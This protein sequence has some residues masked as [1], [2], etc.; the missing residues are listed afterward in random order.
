M[1]RT[2][3]TLIVGGAANREIEMPDGPDVLAK[4]ASGFDFD[5]LGTELQTRDMI[6]LANIFEQSAGGLETTQEQ[7]LEGGR[8]IRV[9]SSV[10]ASINAILEQNG[11]D[12]HMIAAGKIAIAF[13]TLQSESRATLN[14]E[15]IV[16]GDLPLRGSENWLYQLGQMIVKGVPRAKADDCF[17]KLSIICFNYDRSIEHYLPWVLHMGFGMSLEEARA[18]IAARLRIVHPF[19]VAGRLPWQNGDTA[20]I[21]WGYEESNDYSALIKE[22]CT[23]SERWLDRDFTKAL[24]GEVAESERVVFLG[25]G[26]DPMDTALLF[27]HP[28][29]HNRDVLVGLTGTNAI[30]R[31]AIFRLLKENT[32]IEMDDLISIEE[33]KAYEMLRD[34]S[35]FLE[36]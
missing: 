36:S 6:A 29:S 15:P 1:I 11:A 32:G 23:S 3:T 22:V 4:I 18:L 17:E 28:F 34:Y 8:K 21:D 9:A 12:P 30:E 19:G 7:L 35:L 24:S 33:L 13:Y 26:F 27:N 20:P 31:K 2:N 16:E 14:A 10:S 25:F 5:R